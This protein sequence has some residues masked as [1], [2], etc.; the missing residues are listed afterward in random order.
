MD[1]R[2]RDCCVE[3]HTYFTMPTTAEKTTTTTTT[4]R[5]QQLL[6]IIIRHSIN[7]TAII[8]LYN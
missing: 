7:F 3:R 4:T 5:I 1:F 8:S 2:C 6:Y